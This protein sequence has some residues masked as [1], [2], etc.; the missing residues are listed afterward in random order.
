MIEVTSLSPLETRR[1]W[2]E[3]RQ[4]QPRARARDAAREWGISEAELVAAHCGL[5]AT[6]LRAD[7]PALLTGVA[8]FAH[9]MAL[10]R[11]EYA[12]HELRGR[13]EHVESFG[14]MGQ[15]TGE[16]IDLR[17]FYEYWRHV[18]LWRDDRPSIQVFDAT[19]TAVVKV[20]VDDEP[21]KL[22]VLE[23]ELRSADQTPVAD[24]VTATRPP[25][26]EPV[27]DERAFQD[28][29]AAL[30]DTHEF[31][32]LLRRFGLSRLSAL[33]A[34]R[35]DQACRVGGGSVHDVLHEAA[36]S[37]LPIMVFVGN[38]G[39]IQIFTGCVKRVAPTG[40]WLNVL[41]EQFNLHVRE[42]EIAETWVVRKPTRD[43]VVTSLE[44]FARDG[45]LIVQLF[46]KRKPGQEESKCWRAL[47]QRLPRL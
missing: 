33:R 31:T 19:G 7:G 35:C 46:G 45:E 12:V 24:V 3:L 42:D 11:N 30:K 20:Y 26:A 32:A 29:W 37:E 44:V 17:L 9:V 10:T 15:V 34:A 21:E 41:D 4:R 13:F 16:T 6:R 8:R 27:V 18:F 28:A 38:S 5:T 39:A 25:S 36:R 1:R 47:A 43:G 2:R 14:K 23:A 40:A 22:A